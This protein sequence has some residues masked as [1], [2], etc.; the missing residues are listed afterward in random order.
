MTPLTTY[1][2]GIEECTDTI[3]THTHT[4]VASTAKKS[5][6]ID[7]KYSNKT[8]VTGNTTI[9]VTGNRRDCVR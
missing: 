7:C 5:A 2:C 1:T 9:M 3:Y 4:H 8:M 6:V